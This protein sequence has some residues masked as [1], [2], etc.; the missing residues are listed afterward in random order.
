MYQPHA[1]QENDRRRVHDLIDAHSFGTLLVVSR[2]GGLD[3][4]HVPFVLDRNAG[5][6]GRL[7][8]HV[9]TANPIWQAALAAG[10]VTAVFAG[11]DAYVSA[12]WYERPA[13]QVPTWN[14]AVVHA[15]GT[16]TKMEREDLLR[17]LDELVAAHEGDAP[18]AWRSG[19]LSSALRDELLSQIVGI[20]IEVT[21]LEGKFKLSQNRSDIDRARVTDALRMRGRPCDAALAELM[22]TRT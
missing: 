3:I 11:P 15:H 13:E 2:E 4:S 22:A 8:L 7:R 16:P 18:E 6:H 14:Y 10:R 12:S 9:A 21:E 17:L 19:L 20:S 1:F 5:D